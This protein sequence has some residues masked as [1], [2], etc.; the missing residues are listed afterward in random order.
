MSPYTTERG[1]F[2]SGK[3]IC[4]VW[5]VCVYLYIIHI[6]HYPYGIV[7]TTHKKNKNKKTKREIFLII[8]TLSHHNSFSKDNDT[9]KVTSLGVVGICQCITTSVST[10]T[11]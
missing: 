3:M 7:M 10:T 2:L 8:S 5:F 1:F 6:H 11:L 4:G 9:T